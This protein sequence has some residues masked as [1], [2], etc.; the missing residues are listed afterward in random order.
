M[1]KQ[2]IEAYQYILDSGEMETVV[3]SLQYA[4]HRILKHPTCG[5]K[6]MSLVD[7]ERILSEFDFKF[8]YGKIR[9]EIQDQITHLKE[10]RQTMKEDV[11]KKLTIYE[12]YPNNK[13]CSDCKKPLAQGAQGYDGSRPETN[14]WCKC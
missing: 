7:I 12:R 13:I 11:L 14:P 1:K 6:V 2:K 4:K 9:D 5:A 10:G 8:S 3:K